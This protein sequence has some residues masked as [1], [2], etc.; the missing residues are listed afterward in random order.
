MTLPYDMFCFI[1]MVIG[2][3]N[4]KSGILVNSQED[5]VTMSTA[6]IV[7]N[8]ANLGKVCKFTIP[9]SMVSVT[10][11]LSSKIVLSTSVPN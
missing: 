6:A 11:N 2:E 8:N 7:Q 10:T 5:P 1:N 4:S 9:C 3:W